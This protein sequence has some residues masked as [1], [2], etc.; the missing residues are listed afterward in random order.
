MRAK[1]Y[2][3]TALLAFI[4]SVSGSDIVARMTV[5]GNDV[6]TA[7]VDHLDWAMLTPIGL[8]FLLLPFAGTA[9]V[10]AAVRERNRTATAIIYTVALAVLACTYF[11]GFMTSQHALL[12]GRWTAAVLSIGLMPLFTGLPVL[13]GVGLAAA[14]IVT[15]RPR[16]S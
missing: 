14:L 10:C 12:D 13:L 9:L 4:A 7:L 15:A 6:A 16:H 1:T 2:L 8:L 5:A 3:L 11:D